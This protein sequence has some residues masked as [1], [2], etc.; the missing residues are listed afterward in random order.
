[1][2]KGMYTGLVLGVASALLLAAGCGRREEKAG[3]YPVRVET[4]DGLR[5]VYNP[6]FPRDGR[7]TPTPVEELTIGETEGAEGYTFN[8]PIWIRADDE[9]RIYVMDWGDVCIKVF[10]AGGRLLRTIG[11]KGQGPGDFDVPAYFDLM[12]DGRIA[13]MDGR[14]QRVTFLDPEGNHAGSFR[15]EGFHSRMACD[16]RGRV[17]FQT[18]KAGEELEKMGEDYRAVPYSTIIYRAGEE[19]KVREE[20]GPFEGEVRAMRRTPDGG[21]MSMSPPFRVLW[22]VC[23]GDRVVVGFNDRF[24]LTVY[25]PDLRPELRFLREYQPPKNP[26]YTGDPWDHEFYPAFESMFILVDDEGN[27]WLDRAIPP[28]RKEGEDGRPEWER[29]PEHVYDVFSAEGIYIREVTLPFAARFIKGG[30]FYVLDRDEEGFARVRRFR[31]E[32]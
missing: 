11:R 19:G 12:P 4:E 27:F 26:S 24:D 21:I 20:I 31:L 15:V 9:G 30:K 28:V 3:E 29:A 1:M 5:T 16:S 13:V 32:E 8:R 17:Y 6:D 14:N 2:R 7:W 25:G 22:A 18:Q 10:D 23:P